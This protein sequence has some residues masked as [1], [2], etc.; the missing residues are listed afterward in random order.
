DFIGARVDGRR[1]VRFRVDAAADGERN[2]QLAR[3]RANGVRKRA[4]AFERRRDVE[5]D[6]LVDPF[7]VVTA[8]ELRRIARGAESLE[9]DALDD[10]SIAH[11]ETGDDAFREHDSTYPTMLRKFLST[12]SPTSPDFSG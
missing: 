5:D 8:R 1:R 12:C 9:V 3:D 2:E 4:P 7:S 11:V 6:E 10:L